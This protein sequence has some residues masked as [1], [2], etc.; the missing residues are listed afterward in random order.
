[1]PFFYRGKSDPAPS[2]SRLSLR[3]ATLTV[4][5]AYPAGC[6]LHVLFPDTTPEPGL[7]A[8]EITGFA[9]IALALLAFCFIAPS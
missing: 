1:M 5:T 3:I 7:T 4:L 6:I 2:R 9:L 8:G